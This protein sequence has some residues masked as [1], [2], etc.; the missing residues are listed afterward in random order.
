MKTLLLAA[1]FF[2]LPLL[3]AT[4]SDKSRTSN[5]QDAPVKQTVPGKSQDTK[6]QKVRKL[7]LITNGEN[8]G[9]QLVKRMVMQFERMPQVPEGFI[10]SSRSWR[11]RTS[12]ST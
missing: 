8:M 10:P 9:Q 6:L 12:S 3:L 4:A 5:S 1:S 11:G 7:L 2:A